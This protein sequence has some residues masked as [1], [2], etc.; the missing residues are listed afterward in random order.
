MIDLRRPRRFPQ[1]ANSLKVLR[2]TLLSDHL[3]KTGAAR[4]CRHSRGEHDATVSTVTLKPIRTH[5]AGAT[6][7]GIIAGHIAL[8]VCDAKEVTS[9][10]MAA[11]RSYICP[12]RR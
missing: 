10:S 11:F 1:Y 3:H 6:N 12:P 5:L 4:L 8:A 2:N 9:S 7:K